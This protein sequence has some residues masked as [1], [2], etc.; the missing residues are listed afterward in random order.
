MGDPGTLVESAPPAVAKAIPT[1]IAKKMQGE[2]NVCQVLL[3]G[4]LRRTKQ[5]GGHC[6]GMVVWL[7]GEGV[8]FKLSLNFLKAPVF[9]SWSQALNLLLVY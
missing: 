2:E 9:L 1:V 3:T 6:V 5:C 7:Q 8:R 4:E